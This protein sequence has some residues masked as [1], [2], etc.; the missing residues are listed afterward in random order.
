MHPAASIFRALLARA[1]IGETAA[2]YLE[3]PAES[4]AARRGA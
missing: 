2:K 4:D 1:L 3:A